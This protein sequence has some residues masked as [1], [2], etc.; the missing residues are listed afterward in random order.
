MYKRII[1][2]VLA[3]VLAAGVFAGCSGDSENKNEEVTEKTNI[4]ETAAG[5]NPSFVV[6]GKEVDTTDLA[7]LSFNGVEIPFD[8]YRY[9][10][11]AVVESYFYDK[12]D[13]YWESDEGEET[14]SQIKDYVI[15]TLKNM[16]WGKILAAD[17]NIEL[18]QEDYD[19]IEAD[20]EETKNSF[21]SDG[22]YQDALDAAHVDEET[23]KTLSE[24][25]YYSQRAYNELFGEGGEYEVTDDEFNEKLANEY[26]RVQH[27]LVSF[28][29]FL[30]DE[31]YA[32]ATDDEIKQAA[33][34]AANELLER[35]NN[36][37]DFYTLASENSDDPGMTSEDGYYFTYGIMV[38]PFEEAS[39][40]LKENEVSG[41][42]ETSYGYHIIKRLPMEQEYIDENYDALKEDYIALQFNAL[43]N[44]LMNNLD[45]EYSDYYKNMTGSSI[46]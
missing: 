39:Y 28:D 22:S 34:S 36:G 4:E 5:D 2:G 26:V 43:V 30:E 40:A 11:L 16:V 12:D 15:E 38:E 13:D 24:Y 9:Y 41:L 42:V 8:V 3:A 29:R 32:D 14:F 19:G 21:S 45:I 17:N 20:I 1:A 46:K 7:L 37:E 31:E 6:D 44:D 33:E 35:V 25:N 18:T 27:I 23:L 10:Y